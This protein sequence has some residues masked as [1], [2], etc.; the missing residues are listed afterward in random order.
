M[1]FRPKTRKTEYQ[2]HE[3]SASFRSPP[4]CLS[5][6]PLDRAETAASTQSRIQPVLFIALDRGRLVESRYI[7]NLREDSVGGSIPALLQ[8]TSPRRPG[9]PRSMAPVHTQSRSVLDRTQLPDVVESSSNSVPPRWPVATSA[10]D[11]ILEGLL[12]WAQ[13]P[14]ISNHDKP[15]RQEGNSYIWPYRGVLSAT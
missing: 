11:S 10:V 4:A 2:I 8:E 1:R 5:A 6:S 13:D 15:F 7:H 9:W 14:N 3:S 12:K